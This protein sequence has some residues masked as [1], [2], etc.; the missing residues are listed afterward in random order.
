MPEYGRATG[1][2]LNVVTKSG[3]NEF[4]GMVWGNWTP[5]AHRHP[6]VPSEALTSPAP[7]AKLSNTVD[8]GATVGRPHHQ[9]QAVVLRR[10]R[11]FVQLD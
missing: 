4:H 10:L 1:G 2:V 8:F 6:S 7:E 5:A 9:G 3:S 11:P